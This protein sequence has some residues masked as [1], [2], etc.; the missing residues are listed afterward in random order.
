MRKDDE[1]IDYDELDRLADEHKPKMIIVGRER[2]PARHRFRAHPA[3]SPTASA[4][5]MVTDMA[6]IAGLVAGG[7][8]SEPG[9]RT[10]TSSRRPRTRRCADRAAAWCCAASKYAKDLDKAVFPGVQGGPLMHIIAA[11]AV[12]FKEAAEPAFADVPAADRRERA[13]A[14]G[15]A[16]RGAASASSAAARTTT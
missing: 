12:C 6:H 9:A 8:A 11:K 13:A 15:G 4:P 14:R 2:L 1:R 10:P 7:R 3:R 16:R 5:P